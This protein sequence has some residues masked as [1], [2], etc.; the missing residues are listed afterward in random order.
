[1]SERTK[2]T[3]PRYPEVTVE[4][5]GHDGNAF[6]ILGACKRAARKS[7]LTD[8]EIARFYDEA[9]AGDYDDLLAKAMEWFHVE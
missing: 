1:M 9:T 2:S 4:L 8:E 6:A 5:L 7:G 3:G